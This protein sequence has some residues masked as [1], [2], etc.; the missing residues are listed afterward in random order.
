MLKS[1]S[2]KIGLILSISI[3]VLA[4]VP[5][6]IR[7]NAVQFSDIFENLV[8]LFISVFVSLMIH[9]FFLTRH[10]EK[11]GLQN[12]I[13]KGILANAL[14]MAFVMGLTYTF[15]KDRFFPLTNVSA[16]AQGLGERQIFLSYFFRSLIISSITYFVAVYFRITNI[17]QHSIL[18][19]EYLKQENLK[20]ALA[21]LRE[22]ISPHFL[23]NSLNTLS[24]LTK[25]DDVKEYIVR[26]SDVYRY[27][28]HFQ[29]KNEV[30][31]GEEMDFIQSY[32][33]ILK[34]RFEDGLRINIQLDETLLS[35]KIMPMALQ[36]L[37]ENALKHNII[38][39]SK[40]LTITIFERDQYLV[41]RNNC[42]YKAVFPG[43]PG[44]GIRNLRQR[45]KLLC[46]KEIH[47]KNDGVTFEVAIPFLP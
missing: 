41:I 35:H 22:Q 43:R 17:L 44:L 32:I 8:Y 46:N 25:E 38:S 20:A 1:Y 36:L 7:F 45:Y 40:P 2:V 12:N 9:Q 28:L 15:G 16:Q 39:P 10:F 21:S 33:F 26:L 14:C 47:I 6:L 30:A 34:S 37:V 42:Q 27:V 18:E 13:I 19:N 4:S 3:A 29:E 31:L 11:Y 5:R 23:F 24:T